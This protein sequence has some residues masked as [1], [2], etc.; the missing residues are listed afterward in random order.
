[1]KF[2]IELECYN[3]DR[4]TIVAALRNNGIN[5]RL[6]NYTDRDYSV[7]QVKTDC[8]IIGNE[9]FELVSPVLEGE[10]GIREVRR[11]VEVLR[12]CNVKVNNSCG[13]HVHHD[14]RTWGIRQFRNLFKRF[15]KHEAAMDSIMEPN[16]RANSNQYIRSLGMGMDITDIRTQESLFN[17]ID[18][19]NSV[20][21]LADLWHSRYMKLN[22]QCFF[23]SGTVEFRHHHGTVNADV[24]ERYIRLTAGMVQQ[25]N[26]NRAVR[27]FPKQVTTA[28]S[29]ELMLWTMRKQGALSKQWSDAVMSRA[30][31]VAH[32][33][34]INA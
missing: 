20:N 2:G 32:K 8:S 18:R 26:D 22:M 34:A 16:R 11:A 15:V 23:R 19:C 30:K 9:G 17:Q 1:M 7:W 33:E 14:V 10:A 12:L 24:V 21:K 6:G 27:A 3:A 13:F 5:A 25:A 4:L 31:A 29:L 28:Y